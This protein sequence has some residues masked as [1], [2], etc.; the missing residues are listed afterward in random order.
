MPSGIFCSVS[1]SIPIFFSRAGVI[2]CKRASCKL[3][4]EACSWP[5][6]PLAAA[7]RGRG[8][9]P[10]GLAF[11][12]Q[13]GTLS[14]GLGWQK[15]GAG[16]A[17]GPG[18][19]DSRHGWVG[20]SLGSRAQH[21]ELKSRTQCPFSLLSGSNDPTSIDYELPLGLTRW[22]EHHL[23]MCL[24]VMRVWSGA[25]GPGVLVTPGN[26]QEL[27]GYQNLRQQPGVRKEGL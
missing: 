4:G 15:R 10:K 24:Y 7:V 8:Q 3:L 9:N 12:A 27:A 1:P 25:G 20:E 6:I 2:N 22:E 18:S 16:A 11:A 17:A 23:E 13:F 14:A 5:G 21:T 26:W 19:G